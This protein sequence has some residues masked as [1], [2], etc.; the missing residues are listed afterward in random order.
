MQNQTLTT[1]EVE[2]RMEERTPELSVIIPTFNESDNVREIV[3]RL[4]SCMQGIFWE[5][6]FVDDDSPDGTSDRIREIARSDRRVRCVQR[7]GRRGLSSACTEGLLASSAPYLAIMDADGQ[8]DETVL[9]R[10]L[11]ILKST[12]ID[13]VVGSRYVDG[14]GIGNWNASRAKMSKFA[15]GLSRLVI[16]R[17]LSDPMSGFFAFR[18]EVLTLAVRRLSNLGFK[19]LVDLL[20]SSSQPL[21]VKEVPYE[22]RNRLAGESKLDSQAMWDYFMLLMDKLVGRIVPI[23]FVA[24]ALVGCVGVLIHFLILTILFRVNGTSFAFGQLTAS[25]VAMISNFAMNNALTFRDRRLKGWRWVSGLILFMLVCGI[26]AAANVGIAAYL[27]SQNGMW[28]VAA[29]A[30]VAVGAVWNYAVSGIYTWG[31]NKIRRG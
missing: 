11:E 31:G 19:I 3:K 18:R 6:I 5:A 30:G 24:F 17:E 22:F 29:L 25:A 4:D 14:G 26:G 2:N 23:R 1:Q 7:I 12:D 27:F 13:I 9:P 15:T 8:H 16:K 10:M 21:R 28:V 20:A